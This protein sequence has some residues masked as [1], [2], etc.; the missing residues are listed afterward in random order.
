MSELN[1]LHFDPSD[2][3]PPDPS[4]WEPPDPSDWKPPDPSDWKPPDPSN[5]SV[6]SKRN[7][8]GIGEQQE[9]KR[10]KLRK[11]LATIPPKSQDR[12]P[13]SESSSSFCQN[14][15]SNF[16]QENLFKYL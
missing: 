2:W 1:K 7:T 12:D 10:K 6:I 9:Q 8:P 3:E 14:T 15:I 13:Y 11:D 4:D 5:H 16:L